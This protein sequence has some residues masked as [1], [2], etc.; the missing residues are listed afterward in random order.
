MIGHMQERHK[1]LL[2]RYV[3][4]FSVLLIAFLDLKDSFTLH[5]W[6]RFNCLQSSY[7]L[8]QYSDWLMFSSTSLVVMIVVV[9]SKFISEFALVWI[10]LLTMEFRAKLK[11]SYKLISGIVTRIKCLSVA[12]SLKEFYSLE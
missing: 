8:L 12:S 11:S 4:V 2:H 3:A 6:R 9:F 1:E 5:H 10:V 7:S